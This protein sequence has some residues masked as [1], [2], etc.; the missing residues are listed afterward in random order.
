M[1]LGDRER[2]QLQEIEQGLAASDPEFVA[3]VKRLNSGVPRGARLLRSALVLLA[4][5]VVGLAAMVC[6]VWLS[7]AVLIVLGAAVTAGPAVL[8]GWRACAEHRVKSR[9]ATAWQ[10]PSRVR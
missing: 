2:Q 6:G 3:K 4:T 1:A 7:A 5:Y 9:A 8:V 10:G